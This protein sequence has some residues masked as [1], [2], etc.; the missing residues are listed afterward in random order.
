[1]SW[2]FCIHLTSCQFDVL[3]PFKIYPDLSSCS[4][5]KPDSLIYI[6]V[7]LNVVSQGKCI[8]KSW[9][10]DGDNDCEDRSDE[11]SCESSVCKAPTQPCANDSSTCLPPNKICDGR[12]DCADHSDEGPFCGECMQGF[13][14]RLICCIASRFDKI[15]IISTLNFNWMSHAE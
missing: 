1:M 8:S 14:K 4:Q 6:A 15:W 9:V 2:S 5:I 10:C 13:D 3:P 7:W 12:N 11:E